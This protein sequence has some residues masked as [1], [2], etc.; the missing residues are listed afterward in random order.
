[1]GRP[2][3]VAPDNTPL[4]ERELLARVFR[5]L[6]EAR[7]LSI[8]EL[9]IEHGELSQSELFQRLNIPQSRASEHLHCLVW[10]GF[11][12][13]E[14]RG[15]RLIYRVADERAQEFL[16]LARTFLSENEAAITTCRAL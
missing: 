9:I 5:T 7:R 10:C 11:L 3:T 14:R 4:P 1:M 12:T 2:A 6:G 13:V 16:R 15:R 8:I